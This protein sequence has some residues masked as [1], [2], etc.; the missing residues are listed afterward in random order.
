M[1]ELICLSIE[2]DESISFS[3]VEADFVPVAFRVAAKANVD[4]ML[5]GFRRVHGIIIDEHFGSGAMKGD[6][7]PLNSWIVVLESWGHRWVAGSRSGSY[8]PCPVS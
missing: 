7:A 8:V 2:F 6:L 3:A 5:A 4:W 1:D